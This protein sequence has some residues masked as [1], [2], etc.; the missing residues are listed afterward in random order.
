MDGGCRVP[1]GNPGSKKM[2]SFPLLCKEG[3]GEVESVCKLYLIRYTGVS[4][5]IQNKKMRRPITPGCPYRK[6]NFV[7]YK[8]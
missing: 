5:Q 2:V 7:Q 4:N 6:L 1:Q 8:R 3:P